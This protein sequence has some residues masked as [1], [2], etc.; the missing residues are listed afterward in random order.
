MQKEMKQG[1]AMSCNNGIKCSHYK[2]VMIKKDTSNIKSNNHVA[3]MIHTNI[4][5]ESVS[6]KSKIP[7]KHIDCTY[8]FANDNAKKKSK[9][10][11]HFNKFSHESQLSSKMADELTNKLSVISI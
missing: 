8:F 1:T 11:D 6:Y 7:C 3:D 10:I 2:R 5:V 9:S 4:A